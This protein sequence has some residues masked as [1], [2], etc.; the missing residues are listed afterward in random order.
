MVQIEDVVADYTNHVKSDYVGLWMIAAGVCDELGK[1][2]DRAVME[3]SLTIVA[4][5]EQEWLGLGHDPNLADP[6]C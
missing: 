5:I 4:Q 2:N 6:I 1:G 3:K